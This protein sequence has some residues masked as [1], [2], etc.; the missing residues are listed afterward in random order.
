VTEHFRPAVWGTCRLGEGAGDD[1]LLL[2]LGAPER[3]VRSG[4]GQTGPS[5]GDLV[6]VDGD[7]PVARRDDGRL[8]AARGLV[9]SLLDP[10]GAER[11]LVLAAPDPLAA[12]QRLRREGERFWRGLRAWG[13]LP[14]GLRLW[15]RSLL[16]AHDAALGEV[17]DVLTALADAGASGPFG[18]DPTAPAVELPPLDLELPEDG[19][20]WERWFVSPDGLGRLLTDRFHPRPAQGVAARDVAEALAEGYPLLL[21]A[22]TGIGKTLAYLLPLLARLRRHG[23]RAV[24][25]THTLAL[26]DQILRHDLPLLRRLWPRLRACRLMGRSHYLCR[27]HARRF[28]ATTDGGLD[29]DWARVSLRIWLEVTG[30]GRREEVADH[31]ALRPYLRELFEA[32]EACSP[33]V[34]YGQDACWVQRARQAAR[35]A[36][37]VV[38]NHALLM[39]DLAADRSL[40][41]PYDHLVVDEAH[42]LPAVALEVHSRRCDRRRG[43]I[44]EQLLG[45]APRGGGLPEIPARLAREL[46]RCGGAGD[47]LARQVPEVVT[48]IGLALR[49][50]REWLDGLATRFAAAGEDVYR[51]RVYDET[52]TFAPVADRTAALLVRIDGAATAW[53]ALAAGIE[54]LVEL[55]DE[56][57]DSLAALGRCL[58]LLSEL[59]RDVL[60]L[61]GPLS[62]ERVVYLE[63]DGRGGLRAVVA[64]PLE[65]G[66]LLEEL[67]E[68]A[69]IAPV[70]TS[71]T[72]SIAGDF[73]HL[74]KELGVRRQVVTSLVPSPFRFDEQAL[75]LTLPAF[76]PPEGTAYL[77]AVAE[78]LRRL[79][80]TVPRKTL[81]LFTAYGHLAEVADRLARGAEEEADGTASRLAGEV[82]LLVQRPGG[83]G[84]ALMRRFRAAERALLLGT[85]TFWEGVDLPGADLE[86]LVVARLPFPVPTDPWIEARCELI[87]RRGGNPFRDYMI[88]EAVLR[89]RQGVGRLIRSGGDRGVVLL[90]DSRLHRKSYG[91]TFLGALPTGA[92]A[93]GDAAEAVSLAAEFLAREAG[94]G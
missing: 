35:E 21:E 50:Y 57:T 54:R 5:G 44:V 63:G 8:L 43:E 72:L 31:P 59:E 41:G 38:V 88:R 30:N 73:S 24:V 69:G 70:L 15:V 23:G 75:V 68:R 94:R 82:E 51:Q 49:A 20:G 53:T 90:L 42:R 55:P 10:L 33:A 46:S 1:R 12:E 66:P 80:R 26:Q 93:C 60:L 34:C 86:I 91:A 22:G 85:S 76:P 64:T 39:H 83:G 87:Q 25:A 92:R 62:P 28:L 18:A 32:A 4:T 58:E 48:A 79:V 13:E 65:A 71:A 77:A 81:V 3:L 19:P 67:W 89:L 37:L 78:L 52:E 29:R 40:V 61:T 6:L 74:A 45:P 2:D 11:D 27:V 36:D 16:A 56:A 9:W 14:A 84:A 17:V 7:G 47:G